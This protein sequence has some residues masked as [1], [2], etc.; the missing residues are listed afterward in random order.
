VLFLAVAAKPDGHARRPQLRYRSRP[1]GE[2]HV[3]RRAVRN[4]RPGRGDQLDLRV[5]EPHAVR[6]DGPP[7]VER[8]TPGDLGQRPAAV[9][10][11]RLLDLPPALAGVYVQP[12]VVFGRE[13]GRVGEG[14]RGAVE[15]VLQPDPGP[16]PP[17]KRLAMG[18]QQRARRVD[19]L[20]VVVT[21]LV[22][23]VRDERRP[24]AQLTG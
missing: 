10:A 23:D 5:V 6:D 9:A 8:A 1:G 4:P 13:G 22:C 19:R 2:L 16:D 12:R 18:R 20:E 17:A 15:E 14:P 3:R 21:G 24:D 7:A 11:Q